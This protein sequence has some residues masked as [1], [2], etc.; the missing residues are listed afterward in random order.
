MEEELR[1]EFDNRVKTLELDN[2]AKEELFIKLVDCFKNGFKCFYCGKRMELEFLNELSFT[3][4]H[5]LSRKHGGK[6]EVSNLEFICFQCNSM[7]ADKDADWF[8]KNVNRLKKR[9]MRTEQFKA[10]KSSKDDR[11][12]ESYKDIFKRLK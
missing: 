11:E 4:D 12:R 2:E 6:D 1:K 9:K 8:I 5:T 10:I 7:K 3:I